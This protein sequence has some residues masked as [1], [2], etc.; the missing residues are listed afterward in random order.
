MR[1]LVVGTGTIGQPLIKLFLTVRK[2]LGIDEVIFHKHLP[3]LKDRGF[4]VGFIH[5]GA[6]L[7]VPSESLDSF[8]KLLEGYHLEPDYTFTQALNRADIIIDC[9]DKGIAREFKKKYYEKTASKL[10]FIAQGSEKGFGKPYALN[11][12]DS[13]L[14]P[15]KDQFL[16]VVSCNTHQ[17]LVLLKT[18]ALDPENTG[19]LNYENLIRARFY[20]GRRASD[21]SQSE[22]TVGVEVGEPTDPSYG[23]HQA[24]D[25]VR[26]LRTLGDINLD[27]HT[28]ADTLNNPY[29]HTVYFSIMTRR[30]TTKEEVE[31]LFRA[32]PLTAVTYRNTNNQTFSGGRDRGN[33]GRILNQT[34]VCLPSIEVLSGGHE[35]VG[36][37]FTPQ[38]G[39]AL[40]SSVAAVLWLKDSG[41]YKELLADHFFRPPFLFDEV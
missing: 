30:F 39:N 31:N 16:Q 14:E 17:V 4:I 29:M 19:K 38:D 22:S 5:E 2:A 9:T 41:I 34:V 27:I 1:I 8:K 36:R 26:V 15:G 40:L 6:K 32:N 11:I 23:S 13:A 3:L 12:N 24:A 10:G 18:L 35:V 25:A 20:L 28:A 21:I 33:Y 7:A 37:C